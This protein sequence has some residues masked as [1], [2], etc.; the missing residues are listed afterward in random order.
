MPPAARVTDMHVCPQVEP[1]P[2]PHVGGPILPAGEP[3]VLI[4][5]MPF[6]EITA[7]ISADPDWR[8]LGFTAAVAI[9]CGI[10]FGLAPALQTTRPDLASTLKEQAGAAPGSGATV[11][12]L[13]PVAANE[14]LPQSSSP[15]RV[16][17]ATS[18]S[19]NG[20]TG[21]SVLVVDDEESIREIVQQGLSMRGMIVRGAA[22]SEAALSSLAA[23][24]CEVV[25]CDFNLPGLSG[26]ALLEQLRARHGSESPLFVFMTG[27]IVDG[28]V[29][30]RVRGKG[31]RVL[32]K[33]FAVSTLTTLLAEILQP[34]PAGAK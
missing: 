29:V 2:V 24:P 7:T 19:A 6:T 27:E 4:G 21:H 11:G 26:E 28:E 15:A 5:F 13:L 22:S 25:L 1:G 16:A 18:S 17:N 14:S 9:L 20:L 32:Q 10:F 8:I 12:V 3:T 30:E 33:P 23:D 34:Q 31:A